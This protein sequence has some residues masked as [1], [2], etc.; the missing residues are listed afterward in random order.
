MRVQEGNVQQISRQH[1]VWERMSE[2]TASSARV[3]FTWAKAEAWAEAVAADPA[4]A[5]SVVMEEGWRM[6]KSKAAGIK[7]AVE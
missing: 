4:G 2:S 7:L 1:A 6:I 5:C 3:P